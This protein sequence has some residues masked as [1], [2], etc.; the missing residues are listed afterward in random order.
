MIS[1]FNTEIKIDGVVYHIQTEDKGVN[2]PVIESLVYQGG[3]ILASKR[4]SY[5]DY[6]DREDIVKVEIGRAHV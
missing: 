1:G 6:L 5:K 4:S 2:N 3:A